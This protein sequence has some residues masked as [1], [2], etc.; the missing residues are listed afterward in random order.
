MAIPMMWN[1]DL[2]RHRATQG[3]KIAE[4]NT[5][6]ANKYRPPASVINQKK[7]TNHANKPH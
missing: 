5:R 6:S 7:G 4:T 2:N 1:R 3:R